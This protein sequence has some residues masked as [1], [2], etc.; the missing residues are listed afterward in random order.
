M[1]GFVLFTLLASKLERCIPP[2]R[3]ASNG[4][5][6]DRDK[7][8]FFRLNTAWDKRWNL[9]ARQCSPSPDGALARLGSGSANCGRIGIS[10]NSSASYTKLKVR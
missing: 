1:N 4:G 5:E 10:V 8:D 9:R 3:G 6:V 7:L 2:A